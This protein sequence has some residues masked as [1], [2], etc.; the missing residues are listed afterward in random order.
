M[1]VLTR[2]S[3][4]EPNSELFNPETGNC[5]IEYYNAC[6]DPYRVA[7]A[8]KI[9][10]PWRWDIKKA[11]DS[12][13]D[14]FARLDERIR[15]VLE[16]GKGYDNHHEPDVSWK[17]AASEIYYGIIEPAAIAAQI[18]MRVEIRN[19]EKMY[20]NV[21]H[22]IRDDGVVEI[23]ERIQPLVNDAVKEFCVWKW[24]SIAYHDRG[25]ERHGFEPRGTEDKVSVI[26]FIRPG[27]V[28]AWEVVEGKIVG[29]IE[30]ALPLG[31][32]DISVELLP[33]LVQLC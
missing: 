29:A 22:I 23:L 30:S 10:F 9:P 8:N 26:V 14:I 12:S 15:G 27:S 2:K 13:E 17:K 6:K 1:A 25:L 20:K 5:S 19:E 4:P 32:I 21:S 7:P 11:S 16:N 18:Q 3:N 28:D 24:S 33:G 31:E